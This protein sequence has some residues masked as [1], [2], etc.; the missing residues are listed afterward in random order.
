MLFCEALASAAPAMDCDTVI[1]GF[2]LFDVLSTTRPDIIFLDINMPIMDGWECL[3]KLKSD[4]SYHDIPVIM[5]STSSAKRDIDMAY[6]LGARL[7]MTKPED[8]REL[9]AVLGTIALEL[10]ELSLSRLQQFNSIKVA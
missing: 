6:N 10:P 2:K 5:Y 1:S 8:F 7:F 4:S 9:T 3:K